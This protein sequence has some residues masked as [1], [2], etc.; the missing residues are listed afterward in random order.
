MGPDQDDE[1]FGEVGGSLM[2]FALAAIVVIIAVLI[3]SSL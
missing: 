1:I 2:L 3:G